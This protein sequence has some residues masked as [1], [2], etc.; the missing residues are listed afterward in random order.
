M[1]HDREFSVVTHNTFQAHEDGAVFGICTF[2]DPRGPEIDGRKPLLATCSDDRTIKIWTTSSP[3]IQSGS[4]DLSNEIDQPDREPG[5]CEAG[6]TALVHLLAVAPPGDPK[7]RQG[8]TSR[9]WK[10]CSLPSSDTAVHGALL[11]SLGEDATSQIWEVRQLSEE[12]S[13]PGDVQLS[14][15]TTRSAHTGK[16]LWSSAVSAKQ[17]ASW[18]LATGGADG[19]IAVSTFTGPHSCDSYTK[20]AP[21]LASSGVPRQHIESL[22]ISGHSSQYRSY[23]FITNTDLIA[24]TSD[25]SVALGTVTSQSVSNEAFA[26][27]AALLWRQIGHSDNFKGYSLTTGDTSLHLGF[28]GG[29][30]GEVNGVAHGAMFPCLEANMRGKVGGLFLQKT[31]SSALLASCDIFLVVT[32]LGSREAS[33]LLMRAETDNETGMPPWTDSSTSCLG[34]IP[35]EE[36]FVVTSVAHWQKSSGSDMIFLGARDGRIA[37]YSISS[38]YMEELRSERTPQA[39][40]LRTRQIHAD[41][42]TSI[43]LHYGRPR[44]SATVCL[45]ST[46]RDGTYACFQIGPW[47]CMEATGTKISQFHQLSLPFGPYIEGQYSGKDRHICL[48]GF[49]G[50]DFVIYDEITKQELWRVPCGGAHRIWAFC[51]PNDS[52]LATF[53]F[54]RASN[55][56][57]AMSDA[58]GYQYATTGGH[59]REIKACAVSGFGSCPD[60]TR[61]IATGG[62]DTDIR[63]WSCENTLPIGKQPLLRSLYV[64]K[65]HNTGVQQLRWSS[66]GN[67]LFS[68]GGREEFFVWKISSLPIINIGVAC[69]AKVPVTGSGSELRIMGFD[70]VRTNRGERTAKHQI[71]MTITMALS[72]SSIRV[73]ADSPLPESSGGLTR[74]RSTDTLMT[75]HRPL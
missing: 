69:V 16:N 36:G 22:S 33:F 62:E 12:S 40:L 6:S 64:I 25:G 21:S 11:M 65:K 8:H 43:K 37:W 48:Y 67:Y 70:V 4:S 56:H 29:L 53:V 51:P 24:T 1:F 2:F 50:E 72:N 52:D 18:K 20:R 59:G 66:G 19:S 38:L 15:I 9:I 5:P 61:L 34:T 74:C 32:Q 73:S 68:C 42:V 3:T 10:I 57:C 41:A 49:H 26:A 35:L 71:N 31:T 63:V 54:T 27:E 28:V 75:I 47:D 17:G 55:I 46:A 14:H 23:S 13:N 44:I 7:R 39:L 60:S 58:T 45:L 30:N